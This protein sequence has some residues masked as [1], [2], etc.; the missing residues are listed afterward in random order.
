LSETST[1][2]EPKNVA[3]G[4]SAMAASQPHALAV[5]VP[6]GRDRAGRVR[7]THLTYRQLDQDSDRIACGLLATGTRS[8][9]RALVM[10]RPGLDFFSLVFALFKAGVVPVLIDPGIGL[11]NLGRCAGQAAP[12][13][14]IGIPQALWAQ[15]V[16]GWGRQ[17]VRRRI[18]VAPGR[19]SPPGARVHTLEDLRH[20]GAAT[21]EQGS[22]SIFPI[23]SCGA[24]E[25]AAILF[26]SGSTGPPKGAVYTHSIFQ[27]QV[28]TIRTL[29][30]VEPGEIDLCTFPLFALFA[31]ALGMTSIVPDMD[32]TR[33]AHVDPTKI[34]EAIDD[35]GV[36]NLFGSPALLLRLVEGAERSSRRLPSLKRVV[37]AGAPVPAKLLERLERLLDPPAQIHTTYGA[38]E[39]LPVASIASTVILRETRCLTEQGRGI[40]VGRP[41]GGADVRIIPIRDDAIP[42]WSDDLELA[43]GSIGE[44]VVAGPVVTREYINPPQAT[45]LAKIDDPARRL[46]YHRMGDVGYRDQ[47]GRLWFCG[48]K[49]HR[50]VLADETLFT[51]PC[52]AIFNTHPLVARTALVGA[53]RRGEVI[54][55][56]CVEPI[57]PLSQSEQ[58]AVREDLINR[59]ATH[60]HTRRIKTILFHPSF[61][62]DIR[63]N[64]KIFREKLAVWASR[65]LR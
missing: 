60:S 16:L 29:F 19:S 4:L 55:V 14:L 54:P 3:A 40:C 65:R 33:P 21:L 20:A 26:T 1:L 41:V 24:A 44:I 38:T 39:A 23:A 11:R 6:E 46:L 43:D 13:V 25:T 8:G 18:L 35:F 56:I 51:I 31:P 37:S 28:E 7:Y 34:L 12:E 61:P 27:A 5:V 57:H 63:H 52:E 53:S 10:V 45:A 50:V 62:V 36:T 22:D 64:A 15:R 59:A 48:R 32:P 47:L 9:A 2:T 30:N 17:T 49:S 42:I 58:Q